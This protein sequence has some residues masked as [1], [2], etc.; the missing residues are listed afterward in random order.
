MS[1][2]KLLKASVFLYPTIFLLTS[3]DSSGISDPISSAIENALPNLWV[4]LAQ[5]GAFIVTVFIFFKFAYKPI[6]KKLN[7]RNEHIKKNIDDSH[8]ALMDAQELKEENDKKLKEAHIKANQIV[9]NAVNQA[10]IE[11]NKVKEEAVK[12][13]DKKLKD[14]DE[15]LKQK[16]EYLERK[17]HNEIVSNALDASKEILGREFNYDDNK[18]IVDDFLDQLENKEDWFYG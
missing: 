1:K 4:S 17:A 11:A 6:K 14:V 7:E 12:E 2:K 16:E 9:D 13:A 15:L 8:K 10:S 5:L 18:K 3:C